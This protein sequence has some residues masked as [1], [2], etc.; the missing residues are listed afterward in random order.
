[1]ASLGLRDL[2][3]GEG[4]ARPPPGLARDAAEAGGPP[5]LATSPLRLAGSHPRYTP[6][7]CGRIKDYVVA[8]PTLMLRVGMASSS[9]R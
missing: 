8:R 2:E 3:V 9:D 7:D 4:Q 1:M 6:L 5:G